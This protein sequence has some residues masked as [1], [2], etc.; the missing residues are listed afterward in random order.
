MSDSTPQDWRI[1]YSAAMLEDDSVQLGPS[2]ENAE[3]AIQERLREV[4]ESFSA[5]E[6]SE[7]YTALRVLC[8]VRAQL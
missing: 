4:V 7:L 1:L 8:R 2:I 5:S 6:E 3:L